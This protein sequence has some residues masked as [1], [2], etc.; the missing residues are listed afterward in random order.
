MFVGDIVGEFEFMERHRS[1]HPLIA[2]QWRVRVDVHPFRHFRICLTGNHPARVVKLIPAVVH[3]ND[4]H[5]QDVLAAT[6]QS[7][8]LH[9]ERRKHA[10]EISQT[11]GKG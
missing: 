11:T 3:W 2:G 6:L 5:H 7:A 1:A 9:L 8:D 10:P 4:I